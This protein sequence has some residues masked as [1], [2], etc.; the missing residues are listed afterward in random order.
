M[1]RWAKIIS[2]LLI[3]GIL[4]GV[5][6]YFFVYNKPHTDYEKA[7]A[8][9]RFTSEQLFSQYLS[10][11]A[12]AELQY[13][14]KV[15]EVTGRVTSVENPDSLTVVVFALSQGMFGDEGLRCTMLGNHRKKANTLRK[16]S[17]VTIK[18]YVTGYNDTDVI[19]E[20]CSIMQ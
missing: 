9:F 18:G 19:L 5:F 13:N 3:L 10:D 7:D 11:R 16:D 15:I 6:G 4:G 14:G 20:K 2:A 8:E 12:T 1:N 17:L